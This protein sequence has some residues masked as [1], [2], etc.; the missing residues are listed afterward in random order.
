MFSPKHF[1]DLGSRAAVDQALSRLTKARKIR[2]IARGLYDLPR[3]HPLLG[4]LSPDAD[5][6]AHAM[7]QRQGARL[8]PAE[9]AAANLLG[10]SE[11]VPAKLMYQSDLPSKKLKIGNQTIEFQRRSL[12]QMALEGRPGALVVS[13]LRSL[14]KNH[15]SLPRLQ[16][17]GRRMSKKEKRQLLRDLPLAPDWMHPH[18]RLIATGKAEL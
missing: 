3:Q 10:L 2:R 17:L 1:S 4:E 11:Q 14:G 7:A 16:A 12:R 15:I 18:I 8:Q 5:S 9:A 6:I 13:A